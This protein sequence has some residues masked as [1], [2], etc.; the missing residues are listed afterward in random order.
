MKINVTSELYL[1]GN[2]TFLTSKKKKIP[3]W[4]RFFAQVHTGPWVHPASCVM[5]TASFPGIKRPERGADHPPPP[6]T[7]VEN[8]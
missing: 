6:S 1:F 3:A 8:E 2:K 7:E 5:G 4:A